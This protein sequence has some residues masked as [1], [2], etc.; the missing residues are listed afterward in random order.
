[1]AQMNP[2]DIAKV[3]HKIQKLLSIDFL[4]LNQTNH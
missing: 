1:M 4:I 3:S 2:L